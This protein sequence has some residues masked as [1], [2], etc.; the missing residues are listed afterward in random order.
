MSMKNKAPGALTCVP[1]EIVPYNQELI[2]VVA[3]KGKRHQLLQFSLKEGQFIYENDD[4]SFG[5]MHNL[6]PREG[7]LLYNDA[8]N[9]VKYLKETRVIEKTKIEYYTPDSDD[10]EEEKKED[11]DEEEEKGEGGA[12]Q[13]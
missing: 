9:Q 4:K 2:L 3:N 5:K 10:E 6:I 1:T 7:Y 13:P 11:E 12:D 8:D